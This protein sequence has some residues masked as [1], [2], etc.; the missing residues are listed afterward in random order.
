MTAPLDRASRSPTV[1]SIRG[2][3]GSYRG[4]LVPSQLQTLRRLST[5][6]SM[7]ELFRELAEDRSTAEV[8]QQAQEHAGLLA[9][10]TVA[11]Y[12]LTESA[13][14]RV[15]DMLSQTYPGVVVQLSHDKVGNDRL[16]QLARNADLFVM[17]TASA[18]HAATLFIEEHRRGRPLLRPAGKGSASALRVI[19]EHLKASAA[20]QAA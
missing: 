16:K 3:L 8:V 7:P 9:N 19:H 11:I 18:K 12:T 4:R 13:G 6:L 20:E 14:Q 5:E 17:V 10:K 2:E 15:R 1:P